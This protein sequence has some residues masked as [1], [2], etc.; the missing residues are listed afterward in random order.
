MVKRKKKAAASSGGKKGKQLM[1]EDNEAIVVGQP[2][3]F[4][5]YAPTPDDVAAMQRYFIDR[6]DELVREVGEIEAMIGFVVQSDDLA[7]R[8]AKIEQFLGI[9]A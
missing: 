4:A 7:R 5:R 9:K 6:R 3:G 1:D 8:V 2:S